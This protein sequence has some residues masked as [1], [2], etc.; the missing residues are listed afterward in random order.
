MSTDELSYDL[1]SF[2]GEAEPC[3]ERLIILA[4]E[5]LLPSLLANPPTRLARLLVFIDVGFFGNAIDKILDDSFKRISYWR[6][7]NGELTVREVI[8]GLV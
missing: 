2:G 1:R 6:V 5:T 8:V 4:L 3:S 7:A